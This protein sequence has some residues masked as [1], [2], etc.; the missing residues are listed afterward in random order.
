VI[1]SIA[2]IAKKEDLLIL[3]RIAD[4]AGPGQNFVVF[5]LILF[6]DPC[7]GVELCDLLLVFDSI[8]RDNWA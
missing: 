1:W 8:L 4:R 3:G 2:A 5:L 7:E 6:L